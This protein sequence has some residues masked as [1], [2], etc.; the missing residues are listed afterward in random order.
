MTTRQWGLLGVLAVLW[1]TSFFFSKV[2]L[3]ELPP[4]TLVVGRFGLAALALLLTARLAG[5]P[6]PRSPR[7]WAGFFVLGALNSLIPFGLIAWGQ[8]QLTS[9]LASI[10]NGTTPLFTALVAH[11]WGDE[12]LTANRLAGVLVG[13]AGVCVLIGPGALHSLGVHTLAEL[14]ILGAA[15][16]Y[17]FAGTY[18]RRFR[19]LP[20]VV[21]VAGMMTTAAVMALPIALVLDRPWTL[22]VGARTWGALLGLALLS[23]AL[24]FVIYFRLLATAGATNVMLVTLLMPVIALLLGSLLLGEAVTGTALVGMA[25]IF[26]GLLAIDGRLLPGCHRAAPRRLEDSAA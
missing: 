17:A 13:L 16:S 18:G 19:A 8:V 1:G 24:G 4:F 11:A 9:G 5:H 12:R 23:T 26:G 21:A 14:A 22:T 7:L 15:V 2:A 3:A 25:L 6:L 20:P 10:L